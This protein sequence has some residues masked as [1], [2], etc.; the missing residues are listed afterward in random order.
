MGRG[1][2]KAAGSLKKR[3]PHGNFT[4]KLAME[5]YRALRERLAEC[6]RP[7]Q[8]SFRLIDGGEKEENIQKVKKTEMDDQKT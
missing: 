7:C 1:K 2:V 6:Q 5:L 3:S 4:H 8:P